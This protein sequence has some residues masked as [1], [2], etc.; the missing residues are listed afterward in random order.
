MSRS[1]I[2]SPFMQ[3]NEVRRSSV[4]R[5]SSN[6]CFVE[7]DIY[8]KHARTCIDFIDTIEVCF[9]FL[10][11][12]FLLMNRFQKDLKWNCADAA[13]SLTELQTELRTWE[14]SIWSFYLTSTWWGQWSCGLAIE[15]PSWH[16][17]RTMLVLCLG[18]SW[19]VLWAAP[20]EML[21]SSCEH[22][23]TS[24]YFWLYF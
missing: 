21:Q 18:L 23:K 20:D 1:F 17:V 24:N 14:R 22:W 10:P 6:R 5:A 8:M 4:S 3:Y 7:A 9:H 2:L 19:S 11:S 15:R 13:S 16:C 12:V